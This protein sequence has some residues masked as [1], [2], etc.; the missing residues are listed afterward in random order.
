MTKLSLGLGLALALS[1]CVADDTPTGRSGDGAGRDGASSDRCAIGPAPGCPCEQEGERIVCDEVYS[2]VGDQVVCG[3]GDSVCTGGVYG[4]C[5]IN[6]TISLLAGDDGT[7]EQKSLGDASDCLNACDAECKT[8]VDDPSGLSNPGSGVVESPDG[9]TLPGDAGIVEAP[10]SGGVSGSCSHSICEVGAEL[11]AGCDATKTGEPSCVT[12][13]CAVRPSCCSDQWDASCTDLLETVCQVSC[14]ANPNGACFACYDDAFDH[15]GDGYAGSQGDC[16]DCD[17]GYNPGAFD[18]AGNGADENCDGTADNETIV[19]DGGL[20][21]GSSSAYDYAKAMD[22]CRTTTQNASGA[23]KTWG[24]ISAQ[25]VQANGTSA[26][27]SRGYGIHSSFGQNNKP[28]ASSRLAAFSSGSARAPG[29]TGYVNPNG[30]YASYDAGTSCNFP[31]GFPKNASGCPVN[32]GKANDSSGLKLKIR[33][34]TNAK[35]FSYSFNFMSSEYPEWVCT[36]YN[37][38]FVALLTGSAA[39]PPNPAKN[40]NNISFDAGGDP[41]SVNIAFFTQ[42]SCPTCSSAVLTGTGFDGTCQGQTCGGATDWLYSSAPVVGGEE[43]SLHF[44]TW[45]QGDHV[46][47]STVLIDYFRWSG[48][49][50]TIHTDVQPPAPPPPTYAAGSFVR[51]YDASSVCPSG[52]SVVWGHWSWQAMTPSDSQIAF[53]VRTADTAAGLDSAPESAL[54]FSAPPGPSALAG[55]PARAAQG[56]P[57]TQHGSAVVD[58]SLAAAGRPRSKP[59]LR[60]ASALT[61][62]SDQSFAPTLQA[63]NLEV[64]CVDSE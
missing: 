13:I 61:P 63:W 55:Q 25:L 9:L 62:S 7:V 11:S 10:C 54:L 23:N 42:P 21:M 57:D 45:D 28:I 56:N 18:F 35:S 29:Q 20:A 22:L 30:Q 36:A 53:T 31:S 59:F 1:A 40:S 3:K 52:K 50:T 44:A 8:F 17:A 43:I 16:L 27:H 34:P 49:T 4:E 32:Q 19:C 64:T 15:D 38:H 39:Q 60:V 5:I 14:Y 46:W 41:V 33:V 51:D 58:T 12:Q 26:P 24:V 37:D 48:T 47:D 6:N 2:Q